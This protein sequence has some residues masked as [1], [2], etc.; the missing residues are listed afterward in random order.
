M[1]KIKKISSDMDLYDIDAMP[2]DFSEISEI[3]S[4]DLGELSKEVHNELQSERNKLL[5]KPI[6]VVPLHQSDDEIE[7]ANNK[8]LGNAAVAVLVSRG[9]I[10]MQTLKHSKIHFGHT[11]VTIA[12]L[13]GKPVMDSFLQQADNSLKLCCL[14][15]LVKFKSFNRHWNDKTSIDQLKSDLE[16]V[17]SA[18]IADNK[19]TQI[20][21]WFD[22]AMQ[23]V[24]RLNESNPSPTEEAGMIAVFTNSYENRET[25]NFADA[26]KRL[27]SRNL[28]EFSSLQRVF[29]IIINDNRIWNVSVAPQNIVEDAVSLHLTKK[30]PP[31]SSSEGQAKRRKINNKPAI[32]NPLLTESPKIPIYNH[33]KNIINNNNDSSTSSNDVS[34]ISHLTINNKSQ[35]EHVVAVH[36]R[37]EPPAFVVPISPPDSSQKTEVNKKRLAV[38]RTNKSGLYHVNGSQSNPSTISTVKE[39]TVNKIRKKAL[40]VEWSDEDQNL[41]DDTMPVE[42]AHGGD[43]ARDSGPANAG[44]QLWLSK[45]YSSPS[46]VHE[47]SPLDKHITLQGKYDECLIIARMT[48]F[49]IFRRNEP[50]MCNPH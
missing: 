44:C 12:R 37:S 1:L 6:G 28:R 15:N 36:R 10:Y 29:H 3:F 50:N 13:V 5:S 46:L 8:S 17:R 49:Y 45:S 34:G 20:Q 22:N 21:P 32:V 33:N 47:E 14:E 2:L 38:A 43:V 27:K 48:L 31:E 9:R 42:E 18:F 19:H 26:N 40:L 39:V 25:L 24:D 11:V 23:L 41:T 35:P 30:N 4:G 16:S 7:H